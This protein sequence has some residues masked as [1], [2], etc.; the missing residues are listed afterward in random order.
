MS[1]VKVEMLLRRDKAL[2]LLFHIKLCDSQIAT[3]AHSPPPPLP[4]PSAVAGCR[5]YSRSRRVHLHPTHHLSQVQSTADSRTDRRNSPL[6]ACPS[7]GRLPIKCVFCYVRRSR[8]SP[9]KAISSVAI[10]AVP[11]SPAEIAQRYQLHFDRGDRSMERVGKP[12]AALLPASI[13]HCR[14]RRQSPERTED[15]HLAV[16]SHCDPVTSCYYLLRRL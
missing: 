14:R 5:R 12:H 10:S 8:L 9:S 11:S 6:D 3:N 13:Q 1:S 15:H 4:L 16:S 7:A 2:L